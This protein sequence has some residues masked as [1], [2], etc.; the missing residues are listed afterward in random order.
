MT[1]RSILQPFNHFARWRF[2]LVKSQVEKLRGPRVTACATA[3]A[4]TVFAKR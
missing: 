1:V 4:E 3:H 2:V